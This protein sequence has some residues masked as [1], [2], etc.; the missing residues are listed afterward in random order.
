[1]RGR[2][3]GPAR[4][5]GGTLDSYDVLRYLAMSLP[6]IG[7]GALTAGF[8]LRGT[9]LA[10]A[11]CVAVLATVAVATLRS[12]RRTPSA[13]AHSRPATSTYTSASPDTPAPDISVLATHDR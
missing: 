12:R 5:K 8:G 1:M 4:E 7:A 10:H 9:A 3:L 13:D 2:R 11:G 6:A